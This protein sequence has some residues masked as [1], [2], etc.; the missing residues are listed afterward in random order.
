MDAHLAEL[1]EQ[2]TQLKKKMDSFRP[3]DKKQLDILEKNIKNEHIWASNKIE[4]NSLTLNETETI[5]NG[6]TV[7]GA[8]LKDTLEVVDLSEAFD[9]MRDLIAN[10]QPLDKIVI[11]DLNRL[12]TYGTSESKAEA[13]NFRSVFVQPAG[14]KGKN[15]YADPYDVP[16][17][18]DELVSWSNEASNTMHPVQYA[19]EL[20]YRF[21]TIH[22]FVDGNGRTARL[23]MNFALSENG[24]PFVNLKGSPEERNEY[25]DALVAG[26]ERNDMEPFVE[27]IAKKSKMALEE[28]TNI[29]ELNEKNV[30]TAKNETYLTRLMK[31]NDELER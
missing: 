25:I 11:R 14:I 6:V 28:R 16:K 17:K 26:N 29:L 10:K 19:A 24:Y 13:G 1:L 18:V 15:P 22:P 23:L 21:V 2:N 7:S 3:L 8:S 20:H 4:G 9:Y 30:E 12:V 5:L 31:I 27:Y